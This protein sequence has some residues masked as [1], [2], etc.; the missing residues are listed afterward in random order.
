MINAYKQPPS[1]SLLDKDI[2]DIF[3]QQ[4]GF[5]EQ[6]R[7]SLEK[8][9]IQRWMRRFGEQEEIG[10][11]ILCLVGPPGVGKTSFA[12]IIAKA[13]NKKLFVVN[14]NSVFDPSYL[15][16]S[17]NEVGQFTKALVANKSADSVI[18][19]DEIDKASTSIKNSLLS[20]LDREQNHNITDYYLDVRLDLSKMTFIATANK[21]KDGKDDP[22]SSRLETV[23]LIGYDDE[24]KKH[25]ANKI[26]QDFF[27]KFK[28]CGIK[29]EDL[30]IPENVL[31]AIIS[32]TNE[33]GVR[34]LQTALQRITSYFLGELIKQEEKKQVKSKIIITSEIVDKVI[35][36]SFFDVP[37][38]EE[39]ENKKQREIT[40]RL[41]TKLKVAKLESL[42]ALERNK[43]NFDP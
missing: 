3:G 15:T 13:L 33:K 4:Y 11:K 26:I 37:Q 31:E 43:D 6:K 38:E 42:F 10:N 41:E 35:P 21:L 20:V 18:L 23:N 39:E 7:D 12:K 14:L 16:G 1:N 34:Q 24:Q 28:G 27:R 8:I 40:R 29:P 32:K 36:Q 2:E 25:I 30:E 22:F 9:K 17:S 5:E 19:L